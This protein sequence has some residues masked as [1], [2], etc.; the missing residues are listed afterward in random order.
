MAGSRGTLL[1]ILT[2]TTLQGPPAAARP[3]RPPRRWLTARHEHRREIARR[4]RQIARGML[5]PLAEARP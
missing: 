4:R 5:S 1:Q 3:T 2:G